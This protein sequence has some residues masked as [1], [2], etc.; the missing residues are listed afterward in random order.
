MMART[1]LSFPLSAEQTKVKKYVEILEDILGRLPERNRE[2]LSRRFGIA[3]DGRETLEAIGD[4]YEITRE[5]VRQIEAAAL[6]IL[7]R[8]ENLRSLED[9]FAYFADYIASHGHLIREDRLADALGATKYHASVT[10]ILTLGDAFTYHENDAHFHPVWSTDENRFDTARKIVKGLLR[11]LES[12]KKPIETQELLQYLRG[13]V[14]ADLGGTRVPEIIL[15]SYVDAA[16]DIESNAYDEWGLADWAEITPRGMR[17]KAYIVLKRE[18]KPLHFVDVADS[19]N[20]TDFSYLGRKGRK[21]HPQT[22]HNELIKDER[23]VLVGRGLYALQEWG[24]RS[25]TVKDVLREVFREHERRPLTREELIKKV[26]A[27]RFV[28]R[29]TILLNLQD[30]AS[31]KRLEDGKYAPLE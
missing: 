6:E 13:Q 27:K 15:F 20:R 11:Y 1:T 30:R 7:K 8:E 28:K 14:P 3:S 18:G 12:Q 16:R 26:L 10:L 22:V 29:N 4:S 2:V 23:F 21:A 19:I 24:F 5:R 31:F 25:G 17:D 9:A